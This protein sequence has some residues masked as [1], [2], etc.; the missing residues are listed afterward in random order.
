MIAEKAW[1]KQFVLCFRFCS[2]Q[3]VLQ[4]AQTTADQKQTV[5]QIPGKT[6]QEL[7]S[8]VQTFFTLFVLLLGIGKL[9]R[10]SVNMMG[11]K[12]LLNCL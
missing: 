9:F 10:T 7:G 12:A 4:W 1:L 8:N 2:L 3:T 6:W 11:K 5:I